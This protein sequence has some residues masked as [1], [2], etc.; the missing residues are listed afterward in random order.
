MVGKIQNADIKSLGELTG[1]GAT[2]TELLN[3]GK[4]YTPK[5]DEVLETTLRKNNYS[6]VVDPVAGDDSADGYEVG[7][8]WVNTATR[9]RY[10]CVDNTAATAVWEEDAGGVGGI[11]FIENSDAEANT[12]GWDT[13]ADAAGESPVDGTGGVPT[14][15]FTRS[16]SLPLRGVASFLETK[17]AANRQGE[18]SS[19]DFNIDPTDQHSM[20]EISF[21]YTTSANYV[22]DD[23][24]LFVYD[25][26]NA[27]VIELTNRNLKAGEFAKF[28]GWFQ[29]SPDSTSYRLI[30]HTATTNALAY[31]IKIDNVLVG[32][33]ENFVN[34]TAWKT[35]DRSAVGDITG[36]SGWVTDFAKL[37]PYQTIDGTW[38]LKFSVRGST[39]SLV[40][41]LNL[42]FVGVT[43]ATTGATYG[44][45]VETDLV[46]TGVVGREP[47][48]KHTGTGTSIVT[49]GSEIGTFDD[50]GV[51]SG[52]VILAGK[53]TWATDSTVHYGGSVSAAVEL[54]GDATTA[55]TVIAGAWN[56]VTGLTATSSNGAGWDE[57]NNKYVVPQTG[58]YNT[59]FAAALN[60]D[61]DNDLISFRTAIY[62]DGVLAITRKAGDGINNS[63]YLDNS[64]SHL[65]YLTKD[66]EIE[67]YNYQDNTDND[68][69][70]LVNDANSLFA[71]I[72]KSSAGQSVVPTEKVYAKYRTDAGQ[73]IATNSATTINFEDKED[74]NFNS[75]TIGA[76]WKFTAKR[77]MTIEIKADY[78]YQAATWN[79]NEVTY[80]N[81][82]KNGAD[83]EKMGYRVHV[84]GVLSHH[85]NSGSTTMTLNEGDYFDIQ[86]YQNSGTTLSLETDASY[87]FITVMEQ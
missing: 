6:A 17:D 15:T 52:D 78:K 75:V 30:L 12:T 82:R 10:T 14:T 86:A 23:K 16:T 84:A 36:A 9:K 19:C 68:S 34:G 37:T 25:I 77:R 11:N 76:S 62:I 50:I 29:A 70:N 31:T 49:V 48:V 61:A 20:V 64:I 26:T 5:S 69:I 55:Q 41:S 28:R 56:K 54:R 65:F 45:A 2:K 42:T 83:Y 1:L 7:S 60:A 21:D 8:R 87:N 79:A 40:S 66:Q 3:T 80:I 46:S 27:K 59:K 4:M 44:Q 58:W 85:A 38:H 24:R 35:Y 43:F 71:S 67:F 57:A 39:T 22:D 74:D 51:S 32:P 81:V 73:S 13:Y 63:K 33:A 47:S 53:P 18:G 72:E